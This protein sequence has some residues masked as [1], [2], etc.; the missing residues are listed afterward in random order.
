LGCTRGRSRNRGPRDRSDLF[1]RKT[2]AQFEPE[3]GGAGLRIA[4]PDLPPA[5]PGTRATGSRERADGTAGAVRPHESGTGRDPAYRLRLQLCGGFVLRPRSAARPPG[6]RLARGPG[7][8]AYAAARSGTR[9]PRTRHDA[10]P[11]RA[12]GGDED[13]FG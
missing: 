7:L 1:A 10:A 6:S 8:L 3:L 12:A 11:S 2:A 5:C 9:R 13:P 4:L